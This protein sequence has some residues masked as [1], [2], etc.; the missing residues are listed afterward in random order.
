MSAQRRSWSGD[1]G[2]ALIMAMFMV[3]VVSLLGAALVAT[4]RT[5]TLSSLNYKSLSQA[6][7]GAESGLHSAA[8]Y[9]IWTYVPPGTDAADPLVNYD[10]TVS[11][12]LYNNQPV[13]LSTTVAQSNYPVAAKRNAFADA[14]HG[15]LEMSTSHAAFTA[16][17]KLMSMK[18][19]TDAYSGLPVT[20]QTW[21]IT[22]TGTLLGAGNANVQVTAV[23]ER[24]PVPAFKYAAFSTY[25]GCDSMQFGGGGSTDSY[26]SNTLGAGAPAVDPNGGNVGTNGNLGLN[27]GAVINGKLFTPR[28]GIG[29]CT[30]NNVTAETVAGNGST[31]T[32]DQCQPFP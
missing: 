21:E 29:G 8:N 7:Y 10:T 30:A 18:Q 19:F 14:S 28:K 12:V 2:I 20:I 6:R 32:G 27:G 4:G 17:A 24:Q 9:L 3:L 1:E 15:T 31:V 5:E 16:T 13:V 11:P 25:P 23:I 26:N 22:G